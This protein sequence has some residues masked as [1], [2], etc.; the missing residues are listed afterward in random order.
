M[1]FLEQNGFRV[2]QIQ[3]PEWYFQNSAPQ[4]Q[5]SGQSRYIQGNQ[6]PEYP[7][8]VNQINHAPSFAKQQT[9]Q[10]FR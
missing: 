10:G 9:N 7:D 5:Q 3:Y 8:Q 2:G 1:N 6:K 4:Q